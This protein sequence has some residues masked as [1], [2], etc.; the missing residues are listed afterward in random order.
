M[1]SSLHVQAI[2]TDGSRYAVITMGSHSLISDEPERLGGKISDPIRL[3]CWRR[4]RSVHLDDDSNVRRAQR[5]GC[6]E[7]QELWITHG[8]TVETFT[9]TI[10][11]NGAHTEE[12]R[13]RLADVSH[14]CPVH[15]VMEGS[16][17]IITETSTTPTN[18]L[19]ER[20][21]IGAVGARLLAYPAAGI[22]EIRMSDGPAG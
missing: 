8:S 11:F 22:P 19:A 5:L 9:R 3:S 13:E 4:S 20:V 18:D 14:R 2:E 15:K 7:P 10:S 1:T 12:E 17:T 6:S 16:A 21:D